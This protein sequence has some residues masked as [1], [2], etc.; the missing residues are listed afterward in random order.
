MG[1][2]KRFRCAQAQAGAS[3]FDHQWTLRAVETLKDPSLLLRWDSYPIISHGD[4]QVVLRR[5]PTFA[6]APGFRAYIYAPL[7]RCEFAGIV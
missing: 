7:W 5:D 4:K 3:S 1:F 2:H 6:I